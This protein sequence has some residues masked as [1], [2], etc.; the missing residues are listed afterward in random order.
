MQWEVEQS[1]TA[2][3]SF[4]EATERVLK[5]GLR[6]WFGETLPS[7]YCQIQNSSSS[8]EL[9]VT[10]HKIF[11]CYIPALTSTAEVTCC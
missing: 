7:F 11:L 10:V 8:S 4:V 3:V 5:E 1:Q 6:S 2:P 9:A